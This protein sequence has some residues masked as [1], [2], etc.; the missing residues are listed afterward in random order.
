MSPTQQTSVTGSHLLGV[1]EVLQNTPGVGVSAPPDELL[2]KLVHATIQAHA[3]RAKNGRTARRTSP[4]YT[5]VEG[6]REQSVV[7]RKTD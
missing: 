3:D 6:S 1:G 5:G 4:A 7:R 2:P